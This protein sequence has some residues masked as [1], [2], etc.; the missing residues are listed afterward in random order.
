MKVIHNRKE[1]EKAFFYSKDQIKKDDYPKRYPCIMVQEDMD[2]GI[3]GNYV[4]HVI[5]YPGKHDLKSFIAG[6]KAGLEI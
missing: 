1:F 5:V 2:G 6:F 4:E 3:G